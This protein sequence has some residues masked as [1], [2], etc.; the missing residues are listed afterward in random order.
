MTS[1]GV[2]IPLDEPTMLA[3]EAAATREGKYLQS[4]AAELIG[5]L[6]ASHSSG[7]KIAAM[8]A[9]GF[10]DRQMC[11]VTGWDRSQVASRRRRL[12]LPANRG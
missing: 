4:Y 9:E 1:R 10:T 12:N 5:K 3:L 8:W 11:E 7:D 6:L 2:W